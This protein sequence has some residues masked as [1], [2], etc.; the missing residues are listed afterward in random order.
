MEDRIIPAFIQ[1]L[2]ISLRDSTV[3]SLPRVTSPAD[4]TSAFFF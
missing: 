3:P 4:A 2:P 1:R